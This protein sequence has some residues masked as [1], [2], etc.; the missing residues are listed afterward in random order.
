[1]G[2]LQDGEVQFDGRLGRVSREIVTDERGQLMPRL[3]QL[4]R[5]RPNRPSASVVPP[6]RA[7]RTFALQDRREHV[8]A[9]LGEHLGEHS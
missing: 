6:C 1:M 4:G 7:H 8:Q 3:S 9:A 5:L 2:D